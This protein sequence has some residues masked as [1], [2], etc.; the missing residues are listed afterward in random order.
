M[1][2]FKQQ[3]ITFCILILCKITT[4]D[5]NLTEDYDITTDD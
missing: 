2:V 5:K 1:I 3:H 4:N